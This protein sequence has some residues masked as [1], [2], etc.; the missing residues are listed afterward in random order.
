ML[1]VADV[2][3]FASL[4]K[5]GPRLTLSRGERLGPLVGGVQRARVSAARPR[6]DVDRAIGLG[7]R[8]GEFAELP[9]EDFQ[10]GDRQGVSD[11]HPGRVAQRRRASRPTAKSA[12]S[13]AAEEGVSR[14]KVDLAA[15]ER[16]GPLVGRL[17]PLQSRE[18]RRV[19]R[20]GHRGDQTAARS[21]G[22]AEGIQQPREAGHAAEHVGRDDRVE[23]GAAEVQVGELAHVVDRD[24]LNA[25]P[26]M[27]EAGGDPLVDRADPED[28]R[29][30]RHVT[31]RGPSGA[32]LRWGAGGSACGASPRPIRVASAITSRPS[33]AGG[34]KSRPIPRRP[35]PSWADRGVSYHPC[36]E[37][38]SG[39]ERR[40]GAV[41]PEGRDLV[42]SGA[43]AGR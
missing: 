4:G 8:Q 41:S 28:R 19:R 27:A 7:P 25:A 17:A 30:V 10:A 14:E 33:L 1:A 26:S 29:A 20:V 11:R 39:I 31:R 6:R 34:V 16:T 36:R 42:R 32:G 15:V 3:G 38:S 18:D 35:G 23:A 12:S 40:L 43:T 37:R 13:S 5:L 24:G 9:L 2:E 22:E 21:Q